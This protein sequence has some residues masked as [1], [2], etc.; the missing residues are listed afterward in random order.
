MFYVS[1][2]INAGGVLETNGYKLFVQDTLT[3]NG[4]T[5]NNGGPGGGV[6]W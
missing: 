3:V 4:T 5:R 1:L 6:R 2:T